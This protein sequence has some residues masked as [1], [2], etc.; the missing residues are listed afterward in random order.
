M[1]GSGTDVDP[2]IADGMSIVIEPGAAI[3]DRFRIEPTS[4]AVS[5]LRSLISNPA[6]IAAASPIVAAVGANNAGNATISL[7]NVIDGSDPN[8][9]DNVVITFTSATEYTIG[10][11]PTVHTLGADGVIEENG[12]RVKISGTPAA[13]DTFTVGSNA[14]GTGDNRNAL[15]LAD[16][17]SQPILNGGTTSLSAAVGQ[18]VGDIGVKTNQVQ[19]SRDAQKLVYEESVGALESVAGVN[20]DEEA[21]NLVRYQQAYMAAA[22]MIRVADTI[23]QSILDATRG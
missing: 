19:V 3:G 23:F 6:D 10:N 1:T 17:L 4:I 14:G 5:G 12:W 15:M 21:A 16:V 8:L 22:Q 18:F 9:T 11:D 20:L 13:G 7:G 2:F